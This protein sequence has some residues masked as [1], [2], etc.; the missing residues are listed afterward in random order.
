[1]NIHDILRPAPR[2]RHVRA[3]RL[4]LVTLA[5]VAA[6]TGCTPREAIVESEPGRAAPAPSGGQQMLATL[7]SDL[8]MLAAAQEAFM[9]DNGFYAARVSD[10]GFSASPGVRVNIIQGDRTGWSAVAASTSTDD[11][12]AMYEGDI[13]SPRNYLSAPGRVMC[14]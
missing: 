6:I 12:C 9:A 14:R 5:A 7:S 1:M 13:R 8:R 3:V 2:S 4:P 10:L 11:E